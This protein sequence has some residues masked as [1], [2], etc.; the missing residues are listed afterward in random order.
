MKSTFLESSK[1]DSSSERFLL[2]VMLPNLETNQQVHL[3]AVT[4]LEYYPNVFMRWKIS[5][6]DYPKKNFI[7]ETN[8]S[9]YLLQLCNSYFRKGL[10]TTVH[11]TTSLISLKAGRTIPL[12]SDAETFHL[13]PRALLNKSLAHLQVSMSSSDPMSSDFKSGL[14]K[15][16]HKSATTQCTGY[17]S[18]GSA[19][20][21]ES[22]VIQRRLPKL[23]SLIRNNMNLVV[24]LNHNPNNLRENVQKPILPPA[25]S[26]DLPQPVAFQAALLG[27]MNLGLPL[28]FPQP[29][30]KKMSS[31]VYVKGFDQRA[32]SLQQLTRVFQCFGEVENSLLHTKK[33]YALVKFADV[34]GAKACIK[35]LYGKEIAGKKLLIHY[36]EFTELTNRFF[37][38]EKSYFQT[39]PILRQLSGLQTSTT[40]SKQAYL[41]FYQLPGRKAYELS[42]D[43]LVEAV[44]LPRSAAILKPSSGPVNEL[45]LEFSSIGSAIDFTQDFNFREYES[46]GLFSVILF[47]PS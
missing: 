4:T 33:E 42:Q 24:E 45:F 47:V 11:N 32:T 20:T 41:K 7:L 43:E 12:E 28:A 5:R 9:K 37:T 21:S 22:V 36:S 23:A 15:P 39:D 40:L 18:L 13:A 30:K 1:V 44:N 26:Y 2:S 34:G 10:S 27:C 38:N 29:P 35:E 17:R 6:D 25:P 46:I 16:P 14:A 3:L 31:V 19:Q 8:S